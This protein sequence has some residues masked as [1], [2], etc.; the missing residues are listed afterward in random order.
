VVC[1]CLEAAE[2]MYGH[3][4]YM[5][6]RLKFKNTFVVISHLTSQSNKEDRKFRP[7]LKVIFGRVRETIVAVSAALVTLHAKRMSHIVLLSLACLAQ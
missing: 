1:S 4:I 3:F 7:K 2:P 5:S 6:N